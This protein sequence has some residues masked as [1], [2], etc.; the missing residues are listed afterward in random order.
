MLPFLSHQTIVNQKCNHRLKGIFRKLNRDKCEVLNVPNATTP[1]Q[2][3]FTGLL[4]A[5]HIV[6]IHLCFMCL[7]LVKT[8]EVLA[9]VQDP[10]AGTNS[11]APGKQD[12]NSQ[13]ELGTLWRVAI[14]IGKTLFSPKKHSQVDWLIWLK[15]NITEYKL[16]SQATLKC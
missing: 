7:D 5:D 9:I 15:L 10:L 12:L 3:L 4:L 8:T 2:S 1:Q 13:P 14:W 16:Q 6:F 11:V